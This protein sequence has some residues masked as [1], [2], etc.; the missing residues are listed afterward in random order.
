MDGA[1]DVDAWLYFPGIKV[2]KNSSLFFLFGNFWWDTGVGYQSLR[3]HGVR[4]F[5]S[6]RRLTANIS[7]SVCFLLGFTKNL[8]CRRTAD[9][10]CFVLYLTTFSVGRKPSHSKIFEFLKT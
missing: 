8:I 7:L 1:T 9:L 4:L 3:S 5:L 6:Y 2:G 10:A